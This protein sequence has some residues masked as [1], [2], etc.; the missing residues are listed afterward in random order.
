MSTHS[1]AEWWRPDTFV[2]SDYRSG[3]IAPA[4]P[5]APAG[6]VPFWALI[7]FIFILLLAPQSYFPALA[8]LRIA[9]LTAA[10]AMASH[11][12]NS[13]TH[14]QPITV[15]SRE[16]WLVAC[17]VGWAILTVP[18][19]YWPGGSVSFLLDVYFKS[20]V[21]FLL[22]IN[23]VNSVKRVR[24]IFWALSLMGI[25]LAVV[26]VRN[27]LF[28]IFEP[29][30]AIQRIIGYDAPLTGNPNDLALTLNLIL[31]LGVAL[32]LLDRRP[33]VRAAL[34]TIIGLEAVAALLTFSRA[35]FL[36]LAT[37][38]ALYLWKFRHRP[39]RKWVLAVLVPVLV[40]IPLLVSGYWDRLATI[41]DID[42]D[43]TGSAQERW[44]DMAAA[45]G[46]VL[47]NP[48][49]GAGVGMDIL[50]L[51]EER[52]PHWKPVHNVYLEYA[53]ELGVPGLV[54]FF[55]LFISCVKSASFVR[56]RSEQ[57]T[58]PPEL[59]YLAEGIEISL[60]AFAVAA[61]FYPVAYQ[62]YFYNMAGLAIAVRAVYKT[63]RGYAADAD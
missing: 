5:K 12:F 24:Q 39:E 35:G 13:F 11:L 57:K 9:L 40:C 51:N 18:L 43:K 38:F 42:S 47:R 17:L 25:P 28:G 1:G 36:T 54:L 14:R 58:A 29:E 50:A 6:A 62:F 53:V 3:T 59:F 55:M 60:L 33:V 30:G 23:T 10:L 27:Y 7:G 49:I 45:V 56:R 46:L 37:L 44:G 61:F 4:R 22:L 26:G 52:G 19:S 20:L 16:L 34:L 21:I 48:V 15:L 31:P 2:D 32:F 63:G 8:S 41:T